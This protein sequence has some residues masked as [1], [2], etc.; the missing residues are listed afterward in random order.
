MVLYKE[1]ICFENFSL[2]NNVY[3]KDL[4]VNSENRDHWVYN[5]NGLDY[6]VPNYGYLVVFD[7]K[8]TDQTLPNTFRP[9]F[10][11]PP[12]DPQQPIYKV[13]STNNNFFP[14]IL[15]AKK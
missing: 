11:A 6:Y 14:R 1:G 10:A 4:K 15:M 9:A 8:F 5:L 2:E 3:I 13:Y 12:P 7:S